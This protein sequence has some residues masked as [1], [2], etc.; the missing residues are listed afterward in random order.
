[1]GLGFLRWLG[2]VLALGIV[3]AGIGACAPGP[4]SLEER[5][6]ALDRQ[7]ICPVCPG[8][9]IDQSRAQQAKEMREAVRE[10]LAQGRTEQEILQYFVERFGP[11]VL[12]AP[13]AQGGHWLVWLVPPAGVVVA[14]LLLWWATRGM[15]A[16]RPSAPPPMDDLEPYLKAVDEAVQE[17]LAQRRPSGGRA[18]P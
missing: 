16:P 12:A 4:A 7:L 11:G 6:Q 2:R 17:R 9:T 13:P 3:V 5:A 15:M 10:M 14:V 8:E 18:S 1:M